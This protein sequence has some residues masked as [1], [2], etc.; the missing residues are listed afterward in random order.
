MKYVAQQPMKVGGKRVEPGAE[1][2]LAAAKAAEYVASGVLV[3]AAEAKAV[4]QTQAQLEALAAQ[5]PAG[6]AAAG[7]TA[8]QQQANS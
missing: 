5:T 8:D 3:E 6:D 2:N 1:V 7:A 4:Q